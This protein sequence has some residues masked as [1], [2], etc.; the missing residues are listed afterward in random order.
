DGYEATKK[1]RELDIPEAKTVK[2]I[3]MTA[4]V[5]RDDI[6]KCEEVG[7]DSH[8]GKP[9]NLDAVMEKLISYMPNIRG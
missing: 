8:L 7:M 2:I 6:E 1:I 4:N 9:L 3:A 5:F